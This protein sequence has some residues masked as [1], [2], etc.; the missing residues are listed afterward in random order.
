[1]PA[2]IVRVPASS[3]NLGP[4]FDALGMALSLDAHL[5][6]VGVDDVPDGGIVVDPRHPATVA[7]ARGGGS[8]AAWVRSPIPSGRGLGFSGAMRVGGLVLAH[9]QL[10]GSAPGG[11]VQL[12]G[13]LTAAD[14]LEGHPDNAAASL[15]GGVV[16]AAGGRA[17]AVDVGL[18]PAVVV[19]IPPT[20]TP[21]NASR[22]RLRPTVP[23]EDAVFNVGRTALLVAALA[24]G[25]IAALRV[26]TE[27]RLHQPERLAA[28]PA[29]VAALAAMHDA[30]AWC[31]WLS[32]SGPTVAALCD[33]GDAGRIAAA[34]P[35]GGRTMVLAIEHRGAGLLG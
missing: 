17:V 35:D 13:L 31:A 20:S 27:D 4:A 21:T 15:F 24:A 23:R 2:M 18:D 7:F 10:H 19:W 3:A 28:A 11:D 1:M 6:I 34:L 25:D 14:A 5:G 33:P 8:G 30:G 32:G 12:S 26:A 29:S 16:A 9:V 22:A